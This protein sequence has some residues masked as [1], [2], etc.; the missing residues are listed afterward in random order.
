M[1]ETP[2]SLLARLR[3]RD[4]DLS[5]RRLV[6]LY[7]P[8]IRR[9]LT[10]HDTPPD[11]VDELE[12]DVLE[13]LVRELPTFEHNGR[14]GAFRCWLRT[15]TVNRLKGY[16]RARKTRPMPVGAASFARMLEQL[17]DPHS[18]L[19]QRWDREHDEHVVRRMVRLIQGDF[20]PATWEAFRRQALDGER[21]VAVAAAL[22]LT[23][24]A[25]LLARSRVLRRLR[26]EVEGLMD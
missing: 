1:P 15:V 4:D 14:A 22:G 25:V 23:V 24:N 11:D 3:N 20:E 16:W 19:S 6:D 17:A 2:I 7:R 9:W 12:G 21:A 8:L 18:D 26:K 5:W 13:A 10:R